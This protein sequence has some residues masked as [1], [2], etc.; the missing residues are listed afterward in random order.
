MSDKTIRLQKRGTDQFHYVTPATWKAMQAKGKGEFY[1]EVVAPKVPKEVAA[2]VA[3]KNMA[4]KTTAS[5]NNGLQ[6]NSDR[7]PV[8]NA[9]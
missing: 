2:K 1:A 4:D 5:D 3:S 8:E 9:G 6:T 7:L